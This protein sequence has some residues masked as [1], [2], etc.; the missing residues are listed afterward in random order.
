MPVSAFAA[1]KAR[2]QQQ[3]PPQQLQQ[4]EDISHTVNKALELEQRGEPP[5]KKARRVSEENGSAQAVGG[6][7]SA[8][9]RRSSRRNKNTESTANTNKGTTRGSNSKGRTPVQDEQDEQRGPS[10]VESEMERGIDDAAS[11]NGEED[12]Y[13]HYLCQHILV[14]CVCTSMRTNR[15]DMNRPHKCP[16]SRTSLCRKH[17]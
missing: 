11:I 9:K 8:P 17:D 10:D 13:G 7:D 6:E 3:Q 14:Y 16:K 1:R 2:Q 4:Q 5:S 12:G 15:I